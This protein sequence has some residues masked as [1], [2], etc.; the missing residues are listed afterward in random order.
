MREITENAIATAVSDNEIKV[1]EF[2]EQ[3]GADYRLT[4]HEAFFTCDDVA[5]SGLDLPGLHAK[6]LFVRDTRADKYYLVL[7]LWNERLDVKG[8][9]ETVGWS[10]RIAFCGDDELLQYLGVTTGACSVFCML[11]EA[12]GA[13]RLVVCRSIAGAA[14]DEVINFHPNDNRATVTMTVGD[15]K[16]CIAAMGCDVIYEMG[17]D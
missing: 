17:A 12:A 10:R 15:M 7:L 9:R 11:N 3:C 5:E 1:Y 4:R 14:D 16:K 6:N 8:L 2:L 13:V